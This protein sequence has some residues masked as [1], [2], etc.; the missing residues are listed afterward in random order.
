MTE[1]AARWMPVPDIDGGFASIVFTFQGGPERVLNLEMR[2]ERNLQLRF[3]GVI[4]V[5]YE[6][7]CPGFDP[8]PKPLPMLKTG[9]TF[10]L[11]RVDESRWLS[12]WLMYKGLTHF[13]MISSEDLIQLIAKPEVDASWN[14]CGPA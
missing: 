2:G 13:A 1:S 3:T 6:D 9:V 7:E 5:R 12:Q 8:L 10:P 14:V 4:A 11:L